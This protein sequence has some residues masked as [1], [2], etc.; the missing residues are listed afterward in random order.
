MATAS[1]RSTSP[2][3]PIGAPWTSTRQGLAPSDA[4]PID[5]I[6]G[7]QPSDVSFATQ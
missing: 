2:S 6:S 7:T 4:V 3:V 5:R 1:P